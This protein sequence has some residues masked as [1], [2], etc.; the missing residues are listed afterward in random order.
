MKTTNLNGKV[1]VVTASTSGI[2]L[3]IAL[4]LAANHAKV[5]MAARNQEKVEEIKKQNPTLK[6]E[7]VYFDANEKSSY[8]SFV[9]EVYKKEQR[10]DIL[11]NNFGLTNNE[12]N[13]ILNTDYSTYENIILNNIE[14]V[15]VPAQEAIKYMM[16]QNSGSIINI[17]SIASNM[18]DITRIAYSTSKSLINSLT[19]NIST[20]VAKYGIRCNAVLP[21]LINTSFSKRLPPEMI[22]MF[23][24]SI[25]EARIGEPEDIANAVLFFASDLSLYVTGETLTVAGGFG[26]V[27]PLYAPLYSKK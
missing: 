20:Q 9:Q 12:D 19:K 2:G 3:A 8:T 23:V 16:K 26:N 6:L 24:K 14:S 18:A 15:Y 5:Y 25:P 10:L 17:S 21:G 7:F 22:D 13:T 27:T 11:V 4:T 1:A